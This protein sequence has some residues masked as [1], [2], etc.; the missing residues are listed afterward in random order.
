MFDFDSFREILS[1]IRK[2]KMRTFL[3]GFAVA[4]GI[5]ML[6]VLLGAGNGLKNGFMSN[7]NSRARNSVQIWSGWT[8]MP[9]RGLPSG[10]R[11]SFNKRDL[12]MLKDQFP[13]VEYVSGSVGRSVIMSYDEENHSTWLE[14]ITSDG[15]HIINLTVKEGEGRFIN[16]IDEQERRKVVVLHPEH[17][18]VLFKGEDP[19][20]KYVK[21]DG[22]VFKVIGIYQTEDKYDNEPSAY[23]P[24]SLADILYNR[25]W[26]YWNVRF[27]VNGLNTEEANEAFKLR[28]R[29]KF[30]QLHGFDPQDRSAMGIWSTAEEAMQFER[31]FG[32]ISFFIMIIGLASLM[33]GIVGV[34]NI[35]LITVKERTREIGIRK[36]I[37]ATPASVVWLVILEAIFITTCAGYGGIVMGVGLTEFVASKMMVDPSASGPTVF[38]NPTV[39]LGTVIW[40]TVLLIICGVIAGLIPALKAVKVSPIEA[41]RAE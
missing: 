22:M 39:D 30:G 12:D 37:G 27:T 24:L 25:R 34:G 32:M 14:G 6:I 18:K 23:I 1:T 29:E 7:F 16:Q 10:R 8:S 33:A 21:A 11:I 20:G 38:L 28:I 36:S 35:M 41:M 40:A 3:T 2:N 31:I 15:Q 4:W 19:V 17:A 26:G 5:F 13:E 9:Y